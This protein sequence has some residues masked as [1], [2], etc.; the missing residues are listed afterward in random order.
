VKSLLIHFFKTVL[1]GQDQIGGRQLKDQFMDETGVVGTM[2][3][4][5]FAWERF[6]LVAVAARYSCIPGKDKGTWASSISWQQ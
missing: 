1:N 3:W 6:A 5:S 4:S 2:T